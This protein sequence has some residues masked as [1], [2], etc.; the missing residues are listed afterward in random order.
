[1]IMRL[2][3]IEESRHAAIN[4]RIVAGLFP[5]VRFSGFES[6]QPGR[7]THRLTPHRAA[8]GPGA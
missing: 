5:D 7:S 8:P 6:R 4:A 1:M 2:P 3:A